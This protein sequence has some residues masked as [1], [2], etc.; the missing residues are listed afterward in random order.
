MLICLHANITT[1]L[2][3]LFEREKKLCTTSGIYVT[4]KVVVQ[5]QYLACPFF[6]LHEVLVCPFLHVVTILLNSNTNN[7]YQPVHLQ[8][9][10]GCKLS[11]HPVHDEGF[12]FYWPQYQTLEHTTMGLHPEFRPLITTLW[13]QKFRQ[14]LSHLTA[15]ISSLY[16]ISYWRQCWKTCQSQY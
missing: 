1:I 9:C 16:F 13:T 4:Q 7:W 6:V 14:F 2:I 8:T 3:K 5:V 11:H 12:K 15:R 10:W